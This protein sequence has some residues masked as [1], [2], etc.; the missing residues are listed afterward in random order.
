MSII[1]EI[2]R[3]IKNQQDLVDFFDEKYP[4]CTSKMRCSDCIFMRM[5][6]EIQNK[7]VPLCLIL[8]Q[9]RKKWKEDK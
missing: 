1:E 9:A 2:N 7:P 5:K 6:I 8:E 3:Q 4:R